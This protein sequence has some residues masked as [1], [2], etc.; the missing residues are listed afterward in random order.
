MA[1]EFHRVTAA[2]ADAVASFSLD[3]CGVVA[4]YLVCGPATAGA[5]AGLLFSFGP[6]GIDKRGGQSCSGIAVS[7]NQDIWVCCQSHEQSSVQVFSAEFKF[8]HRVTSKGG[9]K[10]PTKVAFDTNGEVFVA[11]YGAGCIVVCRPDG[12]FVRQFSSPRGSR[13]QINGPGEV[14][15][16]GKGLILVA[17]MRIG[18]IHVFTRHG[19]FVREWGSDL[20]PRGLALTANRE[21]VV[22]DGVKNCLQV[23]AL[24]HQWSMYFDALQVFD[25]K[26]TLLRTI[27]DFWPS[28]HITDV[29][30]DSAGNWVVSADYPANGVIVLTP[31]GAVV[32]SFK[33]DCRAFCVSIDSSNRIYIGGHNTVHVYGFSR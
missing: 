25:I 22:A 18:R 13:G 11:D 9:W 29:D 19:S 17:S 30:I 3:V 27:S 1:S 23:N 21:V 14:V 24:F 20:N 8:C 31:N 2:I 26:G 12:S 32:T 6:I 5:T 15:A 7:P 28:R 10:T 33:I 4:D 16:D